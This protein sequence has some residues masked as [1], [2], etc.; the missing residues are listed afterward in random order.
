MAAKNEGY[1]L[2]VLSRGSVTLGTMYG[3]NLGV[4]YIPVIHVYPCLSRTAF[5]QL[6]IWSENLINISRCANTETISAQMT[7]VLVG[8]RPA[9]DRAIM[10]EQNCQTFTNDEN[11][12]LRPTRC[13]RQ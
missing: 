10:V 12:V 8:R 3:R 9:T 13:L 4:I 11:N 2:G 5:C 1:E 6:M 7:L